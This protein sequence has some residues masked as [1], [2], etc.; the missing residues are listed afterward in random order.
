MLRA[1]L[2]DLAVVHL[3]PYDNAHVYY[4]P[5]TEHVLLDE[6]PIGTPVVS[7]VKLSD[8]LLDLVDGSSGWSESCRGCTFWRRCWFLS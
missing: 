8:W 5:G 4:V 3:A 6:D 2:D 1:G 7:G